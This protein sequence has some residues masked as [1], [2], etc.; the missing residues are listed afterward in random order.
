VAGYHRITYQLKLWFGCRHSRNQRVLTAL[1]AIED[2][3][4]EGFQL[5][6]DG[7]VGGAPGSVQTAPKTRKVLPDSRPHRCPGTGP[8]LLPGRVL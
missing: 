8:Y 6:P 7:F 2:A 4:I 1:F 5:D 3:L